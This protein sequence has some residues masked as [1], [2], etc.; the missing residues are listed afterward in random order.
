MF[1]A[2]SAIVGSLIRE[3]DLNKK[4]TESD[5]IKSLPGKPGKKFEIQKRLD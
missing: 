4:Q 2:E 1:D 5:F 3:I